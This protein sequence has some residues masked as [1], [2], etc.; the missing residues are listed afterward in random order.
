MNIDPIRARERARAEKF[1]FPF[2]VV[3]RSLAWC[4]A[5]KRLRQ[6]KKFSFVSWRRNFFCCGLETAAGKV[7]V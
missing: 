4:V 1:I 3:C 2:S 5:K 6:V 7:L